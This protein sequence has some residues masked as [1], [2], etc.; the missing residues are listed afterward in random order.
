MRQVTN[1]P[2]ESQFYLTSLGTHY[3]HAET[4]LTLINV[5]IINIINTILISFF[6]V[7]DVFNKVHALMRT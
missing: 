1:A 5:T 4:L 6:L 7:R 2:R 3:A